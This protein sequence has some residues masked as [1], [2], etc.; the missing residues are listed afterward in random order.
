MCLSYVHIYFLHCQSSQN[1]LNGMPIIH[2]QSALISVRAT[3]QG[4]RYLCT[5]SWVC[6]W[7]AGE[8]LSDSVLDEYKM[9]LHLPC[10]PAGVR[11]CMCVLMGAN[12]VLSALN[13]GLDQEVITRTRLDS[14]QTTYK[15]HVHNQEYHQNFKEFHEQLNSNIWHTI[16]ITLRPLD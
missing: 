8:L 15:S 13:V 4:F 5:K 16:V 12:A 7:A 1:K 11:G 3:W 6:A 2:N 10:R 14:N 9:Q